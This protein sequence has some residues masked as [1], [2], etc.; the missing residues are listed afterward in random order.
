MNSNDGRRGGTPGAGPDVVGRHERGSVVL[1][2]LVAIVVAGLTVTVVA[3]TVTGQRAARFDGEFTNTLHVAEAGVSEVLYKL[4]NGLITGAHAP[5]S[6]SGQANGTPYAWTADWDGERGWT[7]RSTGG[8]AGAVQRTVE[9]IIEELPRFHLAAFSDY[10][11]QFGGF[12]NADSYNSNSGAWCT[13]KGRV[14]SNDALVF[15][16]G[17]TGSNACHTSGDRTVDG[18][19][20]FD[21]EDN[22]GDPDDPANPRCTHNTGTPNNC[23]DA[24]GEPRFVTHDAPILFDSGDERDVGSIAWMQDALSRCKAAGQFGT[25]WRTSVDGSPLRPA[26]TTDGPLLNPADPSDS[27]RIRCFQRVVF[28]DHT[29]LDGASADNPVVMVVEETVFVARDKK[30]PSG[31]AQHPHVHCVGCVPGPGGATPVA[32]A[33][34]IYTPSQQNPAAHDG[35]VVTIRQQSVFAGTLVAPRGACGGLTGSGAGVHV[36]GTLLCGSIRNVGG[37]QFHFD[38]ALL[39]FGNGK[40]VVSRWS[41]Q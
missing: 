40:H 20:L 31:G 1:A 7:V 37:W 26:G 39:G 32:A 5:L 6:G 9:A 15:P 41:E 36:Y 25:E 24:A 17:A 11:L 28:D 19:D 18:V 4:N 21:W 27:R 33:L 10:L 38:E 8:A 23:Y 22:P 16:G 30:T 2:L 14:G 35:N 34:Q 13:G 29:V 3:S 12:N